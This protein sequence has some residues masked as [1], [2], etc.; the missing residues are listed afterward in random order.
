MCG[1]KDS[2]NFVE[3]PFN[4]PSV[5]LF[6]SK[7]LLL[8]FLRWNRISCNLPKY[9]FL[10]SSASE[11]L[12]VIRLSFSGFGLLLSCSMDCFDRSKALQLTSEPNKFIGSTCVM[13][14]IIWC[15][16]QVVFRNLGAP[17]I[18][19]LTALGASVFKCWYYGSL[20]V[21]LRSEM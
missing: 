17:I 18:F 10:T 3:I 15:S 19:W 6:L 11:Y 13:H 8:V 14:Y 20:L 12:L 1:L 9:R 2:H 16:H 4:M 21:V 7:L 5:G